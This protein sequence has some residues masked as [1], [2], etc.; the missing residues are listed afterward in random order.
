MT[1]SQTLTRT[2]GLLLT[3]TLFVAPAVAD[4]QCLMCHSMTAL[5]TTMEDGEKLSLY[6]DKEGFSGSVHSPFGCSGCHD[7]VDPANHPNK[8]AIASA[9]EYTLEKSR[10]CRQCHADK[11]EQ[12]QG[13]IHASLVTAGDPAAPVCSSCHN[14]HAVQ[15]VS[16]LEPLSGQVCKTCHE[17]IFAAYSDSVHGHARVDSGHL[18]APICS[19]CHQAHEVKAVAAG[20]RMKGICLG[21]HED[22]TLAHNDWLPNSDLHLEMVACPACHSPKAERA[23]DLRLYDNLAGELVSEQP[24]TGQFAAT[25]SAIDVAGDGLDPLELW[26]LVRAANREGTSSDVTLRGRMEVPS[27]AQAHQLAT[28]LE[29]VRACETCHENGAGSFENVTISITAADGRRIKYAAEEETLTSAVSVDSISNFYTAG[30]TRIKLLDG[31]LALGIVAGLAIPLT[32][33]TARKHFRKKR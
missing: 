14:V 31:L 24:G 28:K 8:T 7:N 11:F 16:Q 15:P 2:A 25:A 29:A 17:D 9:H 1:I 18:E 13:S 19:D 4:P 33:M 32:H 12:Y 10:V 20:D 26:T 6:I 5:S 23:I 21:C 3:A 27:G 30:G 22:A